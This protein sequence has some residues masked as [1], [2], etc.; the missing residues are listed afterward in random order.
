MEELLGLDLRWFVDRKLWVGGGLNTRPPPD[1][2]LDARK[3]CVGGLD[4]R[5]PP[6]EKFRKMSRPPPG[7][8]RVV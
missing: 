4:T 2:K 5:P 1:E 8:A 3:M 6:D 7:L